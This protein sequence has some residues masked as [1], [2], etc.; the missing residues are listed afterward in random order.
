MDRRVSLHV[1]LRVFIEC[2]MEEEREKY[3]HASLSKK[4]VTT[5]LAKGLKDWESWIRS[6]PI[7]ALPETPIIDF[8]RKPTNC[9]IEWWEL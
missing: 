6:N 2:A 1:Q 9:K 8:D 5:A 3:G 7:L 4:R